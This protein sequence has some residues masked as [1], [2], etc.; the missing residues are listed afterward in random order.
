MAA[1][2]EALERVV[3]QLNDSETLDTSD[4]GVAELIDQIADAL[5]AF[6]FS[7]SLAGQSIQNHERRIKALEEKG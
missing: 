5:E 7:M 2:R 6:M 4:M 1:K 3:H